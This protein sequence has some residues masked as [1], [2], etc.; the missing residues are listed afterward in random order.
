MP[1]IAVLALAVFIL[2]SAYD[3]L[4]TTKPGYLYDPETGLLYEVELSAT[5]NDQNYWTYLLPLVSP[6]RTTISFVS[7]VRS[8]SDRIQ[9]ANTPIPQDSKEIEAYLQKA[10]Q[11]FEKELEATGGEFYDIAFVPAGRVRQEDLPYEWLELHNLGGYDLAVLRGNAVVVTF[12]WLSSSDASALVVTDSRL[13]TNAIL[14]GHDAFLAVNSY[15]FY[16]SENLWPGCKGSDPSLK[17]PTLKF[18]DF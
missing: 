7:D 16:G 12:E 11:E 5:I 17:R 9:D 10:Q 15:C 13:I 18:P 4:L 1:V 8:L 14:L 3:Y 6:D 2:W